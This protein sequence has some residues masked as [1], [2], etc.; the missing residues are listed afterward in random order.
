[1]TRLA[2]SF[3]GVGGL[4]GKEAS[5]WSAGRA[6]SVAAMAASQPARTLAEGSDEEVL[7]ALHEIAMPGCWKGDGWWRMKGN[8][9]EVACRRLRNGKLAS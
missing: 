4:V 8:R 2:A 9:P 3:G 7:A 1:V 6:E 5:A